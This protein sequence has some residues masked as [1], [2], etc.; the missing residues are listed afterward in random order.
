MNRKKSFFGN[1]SGRSD[2]SGGHWDDGDGRSRG[3]AR[4]SGGGGKKSYSKSDLKK[5]TAMGF[6][7]E[8]AIRALL[9]NGCN[10]QEA[11]N[12]LVG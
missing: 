9:A 8:V 3:D 11:I 12:S 5:I 1:K 7:E 4:P 10:V 6:S 2:S